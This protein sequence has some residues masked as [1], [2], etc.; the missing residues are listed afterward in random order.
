LGGTLTQER[1]FVIGSFRDNW[2]EHFFVDDVHSKKIPADLEAR[3]FR[4]LQMID[5]ATCDMDIRTPPSNHFEK[6]SGNLLG[7]CSV[8]INKQ[9]HLIFQ[10][11]ASIGEATSIYL[12][13]HSYR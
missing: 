3:L 12:D 13:N 8:R 9:W 11:D 4:R 1:T 7:W 2:L 10:W 6:L 5:D